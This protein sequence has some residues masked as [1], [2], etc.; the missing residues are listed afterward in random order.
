VT[1]RKLW[2][3]IAGVAV[4]AALVAAPKRASAQ[5]APAASP[6][7]LSDAGQAFDSLGQQI[8]YFPSNIT[9][10]SSLFL[11]NGGAFLTHTDG[12]TG[13]YNTAVGMVALTNITS[14]SYN[15]AV[16]YESMDFLTTGQWNTG[17]GEA[18]MCYI[19]TGCMNSAFG[20]KAL[21]HCDGSENT[22]LGGAAMIAATTSVECTAVG[23]YA[24]TS[25]T[26]GNYNTALGYGAGADVTDGSNNV[27]LGYEA[28]RGITTGGDNVIIGAVTDLPPNLMQT[29]I[30]ADGAGTIALSSGGGATLVGGVN[31]LA[32]IEALEARLATLG[33]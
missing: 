22:A 6:C 1:R 4:A 14:G 24:L 3:Q 29:V 15:T 17:C 28:G 25:Q 2:S 10:G 26:D 33:G 32:R 21:L 20:W 9:A 18:T 23:A 7:I 19:Q 27:F 12:L 11:G 5:T 30:I 31:L 13:R 8:I 16:G